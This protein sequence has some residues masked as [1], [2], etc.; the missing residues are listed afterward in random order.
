MKRKRVYNLKWDKLDNT[1]QLFPVIAREG[2]SNVYRVAVTLK[3]DIDETTLQIA[4]EK[5]LPHF[6]VFRM[7]MKRGIFWYYFEENKNKAPRVKEEYTYPCMFINQYSNNNYLFRLS[8]YKNRINLEV[9]HAL[10]DGNGAL[11]FLKEITYQYLR[12]KHNNVLGDLIDSLGVETSL[13]TS[14]SYISNYRKKQKKSYKTK[15]AVIIKGEKLPINQFAIIHGTMPVDEIKKIAKSYNATINQYLVAVYTWAI[16]LDQLKKKESD[17]PV[18]VC[19]PVNLRP[20]FESDTNKNFFV[21]VTSVFEP[22]K[23]NYT[24]DEVL[25]IVKKS[26]SEQITKENL[27]KLFSYNVSNE[28][29]YLLRAIPLFLKNIAMK[30]VYNASAK[31]NTT[32]LTNLGVMKVAE[33]YQDYID[34][35]EAVLSMSKGQNMKMTVLSYAGK[36]TLTFSACIR[37]SDIQRIFFRKLS[38]E[39]I[40]IEIETNGVYYV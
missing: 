35:F 10:T 24:F 34:R 40:N 11:T 18:T 21:V 38:E 12:L 27:E 4:L 29:N 26:L 15:R 9:F 8:Y 22:K 7:T 19:V 32:T 13:D 37:E 39:G 20:Y 2:M 16:Y 31:A 3:E 23:E 25:E 5:V 36:L 6:D 28:M 30:Q 33:P 17:K 14:D 1:A